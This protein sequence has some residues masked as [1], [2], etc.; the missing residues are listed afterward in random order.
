MAFMNDSIGIIPSPPNFICSKILATGIF[1]VP[2]I[3][4]PISFVR[5]AIC[6]IEKDNTGAK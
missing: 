2:L 1:K 3:K 5:I 6:S 4:S